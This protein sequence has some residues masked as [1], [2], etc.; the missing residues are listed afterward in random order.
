M[1]GLMLQALGSS[2]EAREI[3]TLLG[4]NVDLTEA[5]Q[6]WLASMRRM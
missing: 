3:E 5:G 4:R 6:P 1:A 2:S